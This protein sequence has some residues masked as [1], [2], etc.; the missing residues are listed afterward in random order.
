MTRS[1]RMLGAGPGMYS[2]LLQVSCRRLSKM[3]RAIT[4]SVTAI[5]IFVTAGTLLGP[6]AKSKKIRMNSKDLPEHRVRLISPSDPAY[7]G[8]IEKE[9]EGKSAERKNA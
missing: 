7:Q 5:A 6:V 8:E 2:L 9:K 3:M 4:I 1:I